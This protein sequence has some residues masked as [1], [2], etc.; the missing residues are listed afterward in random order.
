MSNIKNAKTG[1][2]MSFLCKSAILNII[3]N[4]PNTIVVD[5]KSEIQNQISD[6]LNKEK[7]A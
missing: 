3:K 5:P 6:K 2:G 1:V 4:N 7:N